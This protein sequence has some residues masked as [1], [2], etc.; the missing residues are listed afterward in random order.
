MAEINKLTQQTLLSQQWIE[1]QQIQK[2]IIEYIRDINNI[3]MAAVLETIKEFQRSELV[4]LAQTIEVSALAYR[5]Y[6]NDV[7]R[8]YQSSTLQN[9]IET[10]RMF[11]L[12]HAN[13]ILSFKVFT[14]PEAE[15]K[16]TMPEEGSQ[17]QKEVETSIDKLLRKLDY[18]YV[19]MRVG[20]WATFNS[21][22][23]DRLRQSIASMR[24]LLNHVLRRLT[25]SEKA[26]RKDRIIAIMSENEEHATEANFIESVAD[27][28]DKLYSLHCKIAHT[29]YKDEKCVEM[30]LKATEVVLFVLISKGLQKFER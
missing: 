21:N 17:A 28:V 29:V 27:Y 13:M 26:T 8:L 19:N 2:S 11:A 30:A 4:H 12:T 10:S 14:Q 5:N 6:I 9:M 20:A 24:E 16:I 3:N 18:N 22:N 7:L 15:P 25:P 23:P 1:W